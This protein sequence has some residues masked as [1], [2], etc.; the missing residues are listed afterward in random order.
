MKL[1][2]SA[3]VLP[4][5]VLTVATMNACSSNDDALGSSDNELRTDERQDSGCAQTL[6]STRE[7]IAF[8]PARTDAR[9]TLDTL[10]LNDKTHRFEARAVSGAVPNGVAI[11]GSYEITQCATTAGE[12]VLNLAKAPA[13]LRSTTTFRIT[14]AMTAANTVA[15]AFDPAGDPNFGPFTMTSAAYG[16]PSA[17]PS[18]SPSPNPSGG[19]SG[20]T[21]SGGDLGPPMNVPEGGSWG[22]Y[23]EDG[24]E[25]VAF[26][27]PE[28][29]SGGVWSCEAHE[30]VC[31]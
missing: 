29:C 15:Y 24:Y 22:V 18:P 13:G 12:L 21:P 2:L 16:A 5:F 28:A 14:Q 25:C 17:K 23:C 9:Y 3:L 7:L 11:A 26:T 20:G 27:D 8:G 30:C 4:S 10:V 1:R 19:G 6:N 31:N